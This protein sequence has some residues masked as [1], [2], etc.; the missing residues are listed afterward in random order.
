MKK[1]LET[2]L[3]KECCHG[4]RCKNCGFLDREFHC[5]LIDIILKIKEY[6]NYEK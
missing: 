4:K 1:D 6:D 5:W 2:L 3:I